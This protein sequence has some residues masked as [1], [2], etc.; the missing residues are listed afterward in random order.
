M[1]KKGE[2]ALVD[3]FAIAVLALLLFA[4]FVIFNQASLVTGTTHE[5]EIIAEYST[6]GSLIFTNYLHFYHN[7]KHKQLYC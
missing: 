3:F 1:N 5:R 2:L 7:T 6:H 4:Y